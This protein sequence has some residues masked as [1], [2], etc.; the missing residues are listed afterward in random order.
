MQY[1][2]IYCRV[3]R[4]DALAGDSNSITSQR[5][6]LEQYANDH[7]LGQTQVFIDDGFSGTDF[8]RPNLLKLLN[9]VERGLVS[10]VIVKDLSRFGRNYLKVG[11]YLEM[12][13]PEHNIRF[14]AVDDNVDTAVTVETIGPFKNVMNELYAK[15]VSKKVLSTI[16]Q[17]G[18]TGVPIGSPP[19][20]YMKD[21]EKNSLWAIDWHAARIVQRIYNLYA[22]G[23]SIQQIIDILA[24]EQIPTPRYHGKA[25]SAMNTNAYRWS[26]A[27]IA[28]ILSQ[29]EYLG[30]VINFKTHSKSHK[31][32]T[33]LKNEPGNQVVF[34][35][36]HEPI[37]NISLWGKIQELKAAQ[38]NSRKNSSGIRSLFSGLLVCSDCGAKLN[39]HSDQKNPDTRYYNC[40][41]YNRSKEACTKSHYI[42]LDFLIEIAVAEL[43]SMLRYVKDRPIEFAAHVR[44]NVLTN[45]EFA[46][47]EISNSLLPLLQRK[48]EFDTLFR[49]LFEEKARGTISEERY[50]KL[51]NSFQD[52]Q[53]EVDENIA[54]LQSKLQKV[55][56]KEALPGKL[57]ELANQYETITLLDRE[58]LFSLISHIEVFNAEIADKQQIQTV[59]IHYNYTGYFEPPQDSSDISISTR[60][61]KTLRYVPFGE[62]L[63]LLGS[64]PKLH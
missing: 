63:R 42:R 2:A 14:I 6:M 50:F 29:Q 31:N 4:E 8:N 46:G 10:T 37:I 13:F 61:G 57:I 34:K 17:K 23:N 3:S 21:C 58:T 55:E 53:V 52:Q 48:E 7:N 41:A 40:A 49:A 16:K 27:T 38:S 54:E 22:A 39:Y 47:D 51:A 32:K 11:Y 15:E 20:G 64:K 62:Y 28:N 56:C 59:K 43:N 30:D 36:V 1:V 35:G 18:N 5:F 44:N 24:A 9:E 19:Y 25:P 60:K 12:Y 45:R 33:R 26:K